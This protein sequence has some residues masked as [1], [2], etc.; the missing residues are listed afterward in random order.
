MLWPQKVCRPPGRMRVQRVGWPAGVCAGLLPNSSLVALA[1]PRLD[2]CLFAGERW[3]KTVDSL[4]QNYDVLTGDMLLAA[5]F[6]SYAGPFTNKYRA[7][8][9]KE[10]M[11]F[12]TD[13]GTP[14]TA[15]ITGGWA[16][17][18]EGTHTMWH[19][20]AGGLL[21][22]SSSLKQARGVDLVRAAAVQTPCRCWWTVQLW[23]G[24][25]GRDC[26]LTQP[27]CRTA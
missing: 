13:R 21:C 1:P 5:A 22:S 17:R 10:W 27:A 12:L 23:L 15:G 6:V 2:C 24:G 11:K 25:C 4:K 19:A 16:W 8:L 14:M 7:S 26:P 18:R 9:I 3:A 20:G